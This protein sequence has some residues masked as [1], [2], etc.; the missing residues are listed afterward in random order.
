MKYVYLDKELVRVNL[1]AALVNVAHGVPFEAIAALELDAAED[2][3]FNMAE[4]CRLALEI[5]LESEGQNCKVISQMYIPDEDE[6][7]DWIDEDNEDY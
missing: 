5:L 7:T 6:Q 3:N 1:S 2:N 4:G